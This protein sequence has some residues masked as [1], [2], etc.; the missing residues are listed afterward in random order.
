MLRIWWLTWVKILDTTAS[1]QKIQMNQK[2]QMSVVSRNCCTLSRWIFAEWQSET[3]LLGTR[4]KVRAGGG[5]GARG[6]SQPALLSTCLA[7]SG[8][9]HRLQPGQ[10]AFSLLNGLAEAGLCGFSFGC[11]P[12]KEWNVWESRCQRWLAAA[13]FFPSNQDAECSGFLIWR[14]KKHSRLFR[15]NKDSGYSIHW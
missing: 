12:C 6:C 10:R 2:Q 9:K 3:C 15:N 5:R 11:A 4:R 1:C 7:H 13:W 14:W 8:P